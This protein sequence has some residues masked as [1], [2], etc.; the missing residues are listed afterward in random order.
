VIIRVLDIYLEYLVSDYGVNQAPAQS[1][2][3]NALHGQV[4]ARVDK[5]GAGKAAP[6]LV[7][8]RTQLSAT[9][10]GKA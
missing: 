5:K 4:I 9:E 8:D 3:Y 1:R 7:E 6:F 10:L 2:R